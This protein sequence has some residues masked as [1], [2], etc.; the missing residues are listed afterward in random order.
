MK[1]ALKEFYD[2]NDCCSQNL[3]SLIIGNNINNQIQNLNHL[4]DFSENYKKQIKN[5]GYLS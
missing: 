4:F 2:N 5:F 3:H 1:N